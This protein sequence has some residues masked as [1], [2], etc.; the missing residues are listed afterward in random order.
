M[1]A[2]ENSESTE[3]RLLKR[4]YF[5]CVLGDL[6]G[7]MTFYQS[8]LMVLLMAQGTGC[9]STAFDR[10]S[11]CSDCH[12]KS[13]SCHVKKIIDITALRDAWANSFH[14]TL[15]KETFTGCPHP[16]LSKLPHPPHGPRTEAP[17]SPVLMMFHLE[18]S[19]LFQKEQVK[20]P[21]LQFCI[22]N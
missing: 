16:Q 4:E 9:S 5:L 13:I 22:H 14:K 6:C 11:I 3:L 21:S 18:H 19:F 10:N 12:L 17:R 8:I 1:K 2:T 15:L 7:K 20:H